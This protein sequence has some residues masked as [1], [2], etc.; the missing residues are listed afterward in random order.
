MSKKPVKLTKKEQEFV[1]KKL[2]PVYRNIGMM[3]FAVGLVAILIGL[4]IDRSNDT[5]PIFT[6]VTLLVSVPLVLFLN[7]RMLRKA[8]EKAVAESKSKPAKQD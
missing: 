5:T 1:N 8:I 3:T 6:L 7:T 4:F 2:G